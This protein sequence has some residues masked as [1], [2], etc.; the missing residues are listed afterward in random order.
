MV[1]SAKM[2]EIVCG[3]CRDKFYAP[4]RNTQFCHKC[5]KARKIRFSQKGKHDN[6]LG[7]GPVKVEP[8]KPKPRKQYLSNAEQIR[9]D[10]ELDRRLYADCVQQPAQSFRPGDAGFEER[11]AMITPLERV[12]LVGSRDY[13]RC[14]YD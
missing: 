8:W 3:E 11:A 5:A 13:V 6:H 14:V 4:S 2:V 10:M 7:H 1:A 9:F 12:R